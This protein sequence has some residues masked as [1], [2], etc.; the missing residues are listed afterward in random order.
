MGRIEG[1]QRKYL[2]ILSILGKEKKVFK[3]SQNSK[4]FLIF[5]SFKNNNTT[6][7]TKLVRAFG[8]LAPLRCPKEESRLIS[9][10]LT[11]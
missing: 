10:K 9:D 7:E 3:I 2:R 6:C 5:T 4:T 1:N 11:Y 8:L